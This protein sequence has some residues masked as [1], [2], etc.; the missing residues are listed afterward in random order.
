[1]T[2]P[3]P[4]GTDELRTDGLVGTLKLGHDVARGVQERLLLV[5]QL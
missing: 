3:H 1:M 4:H 2:L 5:R